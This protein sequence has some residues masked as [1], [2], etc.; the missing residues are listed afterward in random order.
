[1]IGHGV[2]WS[3]TSSISSISSFSS[4]PFSSCPSSSSASYRP[5][6]SLNR[7]SP[8]Y[9]QHVACVQHVAHSMAITRAHTPCMSSSLITSFLKDAP[10]A[11]EMYRRARLYILLESSLEGVKSSVFLRLWSSSYALGSSEYYVHPVCCIY[12][13]CCMI[14]RGAGNPACVRS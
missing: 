12:S 10:H 7:P 3:W 14:P 4:C 9:T 6:Q 8:V 11:T 1:M 2:H 5:H 13:A